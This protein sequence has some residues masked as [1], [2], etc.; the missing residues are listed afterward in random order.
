MPK[1]N[2]GDYDDFGD[3]RRT[4][5]KFLNQQ[6][7]AKKYRNDSWTNE[8]VASDVKFLKFDQCRKQGKRTDRY[9]I[10][11][12]KDRVRMDWRNHQQYWEE[13]S[14]SSQE[15]DSED[16]CPKTPPKEKSENEGHRITFADQVTGNKHKLCNVHYVESFKEYNEMEWYECKEMRE[17]ISEI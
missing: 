7:L 15:L 17:D 10:V 3:H 5:S 2:K 14:C 13:S 9:G 4:D 6:K 8:D 11:I 16:E 1:A 12:K